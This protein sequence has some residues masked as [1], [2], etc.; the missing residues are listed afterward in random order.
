MN[1]KRPGR[2]SEQFPLRLPDGM[3]DRI[4]VSAERNGRSMNAEILQ[5]LEQY[6]PPEPSIG[7]LIDNIEK[8]IEQVGN[9]DSEAYNRHLLKILDDL[10]HR[11]SIGVDFDR[12]SQRTRTLGEARVDHDTRLFN[13]AFHRRRL[14][15]DRAA[16]GI[17][18]GD[19]QRLLDSEFLSYLSLD[20]LNWT[21]NVLNHELDPNQA[22]LQL[23]LSHL[24]FED[25]EASMMALKK[26][27]EIEIKSRIEFHEGKDELGEGYFSAYPEVGPK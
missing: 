13:E 18:T 14:A 17:E 22:L 20:R 10:H 11:L 9:P 25:P 27:V 16:H 21:L 15:A 23:N 1:D 19:W 12:P 5:A 2:G 4:K 3:R 6:F 8:T 7:D 24:R 26:A